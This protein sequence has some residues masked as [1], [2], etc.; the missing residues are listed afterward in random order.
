[1]KNKGLITLIAI[2]IFLFLAIRNC[3]ST[4]TPTYPTRDPKVTHIYWMSA[5]ATSDA[6][7]AQWKIE[8][9]NQAHEAEYERTQLV[10]ESRQCCA[11]EICCQYSNC[12]SSAPVRSGSIELSQ[13]PQG[14]TT[15]I[16]GC[17]IKGNISFDT[18]EKIYYVK[19][20][21]FYD[22]TT[23]NPEYGERWFCTEE[24]AKANGWRKALN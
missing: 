10:I 1:M 3:Y 22:D 13:C 19:G 20:Q 12:C 5:Q 14:C 2:A 6:E 16:A 15:H 21:T 17:D 7:Q 4:P 23:I 9:T 18:K 8:E 24:E 11:D